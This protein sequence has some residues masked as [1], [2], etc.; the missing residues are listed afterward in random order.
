MN[1]IQPAPA[2]EGALLRQKIR[3]LLPDLVDASDRLVRHPQIA[4]LYPE[5][6][7]TSHCIIRASVP[8]MEAGRARAAELAG[9]DPVAAGLATYLEGHI[10]EELHHDQ[11]LL[12]DLETLGRAR[13]DVLARPPSATVSRSLSGRSTTGSTTTTPWRCSATSPCSR[14]TRRP[15]S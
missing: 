3:I 4:A 13:S 8:L 7:F 9:S 5:F 6:L 2:G 15:A 1:P 11:W 12:D 10:P 14:D